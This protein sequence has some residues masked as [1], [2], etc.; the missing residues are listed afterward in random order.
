[1]Y[2]QTKRWAG[3]QRVTIYMCINRSQQL[4]LHYIWI[5]YKNIDAITKFQL[6]IEKKRFVY[7]CVFLGIMTHIAPPQLYFKKWT[8]NSPLEQWSEYHEKTRLRQLLFHPSTNHQQRI[9]IDRPVKTSL[10]APVS[11]F[12]STHQLIDLP[13]NLPAK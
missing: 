6:K 9:T 8:D 11:C 5:E 7:F 4:N 12:F 1:M 2:F 10:W 13:N 3:T